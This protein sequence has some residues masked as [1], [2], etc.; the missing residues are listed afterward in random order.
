MEATSASLDLAKAICRTGA[1]AG[2]EEGADAQPRHIFHAWDLLAE[3]AGALPP[4]LPPPP[5][6]AVVAA[7][8][9]TSLQLAPLARVAAVRFVLIAS[10]IDMM[11]PR[12]ES[13]SKGALVFSL[14]FAVSKSSRVSAMSTQYLKAG[15]R[16]RAAR[17][18]DRKPSGAP[19]C[20]W[21]VR[22]GAASVRVRFGDDGELGLL[23]A[24]HTLVAKEVVVAERVA[25]AR[26]GPVGVACLH[27]DN[28]EHAAC[29][30]RAM[31]RSATLG[32]RQRH[33]CQ[34]STKGSTKGNTKGDAVQR[35]RRGQGLAT[36]GR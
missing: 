30:R 15:Q 18:V 6:L 36:H 5:P 8:F 26:G 1:F 10:T 9:I 31:I 11:R 13:I 22:V 29:V 21:S 25:D 2:D 12:V 4:A 7:F 32:E 14:G 28:P 33:G 34:G 24:E 35:L 19:R 17:R 3:G 20:E 16:S 27:V 23:A